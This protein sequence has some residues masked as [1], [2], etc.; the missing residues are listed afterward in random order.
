MGLVWGFEKQA[1][2]AE[3]VAYS[4]RRGYA[5]PTFVGSLRAGDDRA[6]ERM[7]GYLAG[8][9]Q[10]SPGFAPRTVVADELPYT[11]ASSRALLDIAR[12]RYLDSDLLLFSS[13]FLAPHPLLPSPLHT[14]PLPPHPH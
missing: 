3:A 8:M 9:A 1:G 5:P 14:H 13:D 6:R 12:A 2:L 11:M 10:H 7:D 4:R